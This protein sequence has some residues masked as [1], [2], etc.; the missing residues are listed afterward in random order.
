[1]T[2]LYHIGEKIRLS[3]RI[4]RRSKSKEGIL[5][6]TNGNAFKRSEIDKGGGDIRGAYQKT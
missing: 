3:G 2:N 5:S 6:G 1:M 4:F